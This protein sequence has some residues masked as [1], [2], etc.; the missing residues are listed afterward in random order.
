MAKTKKKAKKAKAGPS[1]VR[2]LFGFAL[3]YGS[4][5]CLAFAG[6][7]YAL[8]LYLAQSLPNPR[9]AWWRAARRPS[10]SLR[11]MAACSRIT[12]PI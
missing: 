10:K 7:S 8:I 9:E 3:I 2:R 11:A 5:A 12:A 1:W 6:V 4:I